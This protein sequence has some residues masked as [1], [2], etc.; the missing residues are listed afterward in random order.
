[1]VAPN[2]VV[3]AVEARQATRE[4]RAA[5]LRREG[6]V[7]T[8]LTGNMVRRLQLGCGRSCLDG[9]L[10]TDISPHTARIAFLDAAGP[11]PFESGS[12]HYVYSEHLIE[13]LSYQ[14]AQG[15][16]S[17]CFRVLAA[18]GRI[19]IATPNARF[20]LG[21]YGSERS[22]LQRRYISWSVRS[23]L[24]DASREEAIFVINH[25]FRGW[26]HQFIYDPQTLAQL[27][28]DVGFSSIGEYAPGHSDDPW[29]RGIEQHS[30]VMPVEFNDA[31]TFV[32]EGQRP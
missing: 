8:Y 4:R 29:L 17:E 15:M 27:M 24:P 32:L 12:F 21:L 5:E 28:G 16:L 13:H 26:G 20:L 10:N 11:Y 18:G 2:G 9:W 1:M 19:R 22:E 6:I 25:F 30:Q 23:F 7:S 31:E 14:E 3:S